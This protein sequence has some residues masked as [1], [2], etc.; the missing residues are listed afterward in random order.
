MQE[1]PIIGKGAHDGEGEEQFEMRLSVT[2]G[3]QE[4]I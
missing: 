3:H 4:T 2:R 1:T